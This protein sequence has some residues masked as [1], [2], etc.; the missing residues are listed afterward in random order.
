MNK[1]NERKRIETRMEVQTYI[2]RLKYAIQ[3]GFVHVA[4]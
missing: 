3:S 4:F 2:E 1:G